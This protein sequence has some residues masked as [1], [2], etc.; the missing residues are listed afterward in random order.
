MKK[1][2]KQKRKD[3]GNQ[4]FNFEI[5]PGDLRPHQFM[6]KGCAKV[7]TKSGSMIAQNA[8]GNDVTCI[9]DR[10]GHPN[11]LPSQIKNKI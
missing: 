7:S 8:I 10:C 9:C 3:W 6:C 4:I 11:V 5:E 1:Q 2:K